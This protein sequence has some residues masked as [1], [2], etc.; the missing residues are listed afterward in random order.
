LVDRFSHQS[1]KTVKKQDVIFEKALTGIEGLDSITHGGLPRGRVTLL[2]GGAGSGKTLLGL[3]SLVN[4]AQSC[5]EPGI[6]VAFEEDAVQIKKN[7]A[8]FGWQLPALLSRK[9]AILDAKLNPALIVAGDFDLS[10]VMA[11]IAAKAKSLGARRV[12]LDSIDAPLSL[13]D[14]P[15]SWRQELYRLHE[16]LLAQNLTAIITAKTTE[17]AHVPGPFGFLQYLA[18]CSISLNHDI[19]DGVSQR[20]LR[21]HKYRGSKFAENEAPLVIG[22]HGIA[23]AG[24]RGLAG[25]SDTAP[26]ERVSSGIARLDTMLGGGFF[27]G[28]CV[29]VTGSP[30]TAKS[31]LGGEFAA[32]ACRRKEKTLIYS[33]DSGPE[34]MIRNLASV[35]IDLRRGV[36]QGLLRIESA[37]AGG[38]S[39]DICLF[40]IMA[41]ARRHAARNLVI[42][43]ITSLGKQGNLKTAHSV[44]E[45]LAD[46][47]KAEGITLFCTS[48]LGGA[49][50]AVEATQLQIST[51]ADTWIHLS[52]LVKGGERNRALTIIKSRGT[53]HSNQVREL[54]LSD[55]GVTLEDVYAAGGEVLMGTLR[56]E[57]EQAMQIEQDRLE[58]ESRSRQK[59]I[60]AEEAELANRIKSLEADLA[61]LRVRREQ[62][63]K[64]E[65]ERRRKQQE[66]L[67]GVVVRRSGD[68][69]PGAGSKK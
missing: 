27:R 59:T 46:W 47:A 24:V 58:S 53:A 15:A 41:L 63:T 64:A 6:F 28:S 62:L 7:V 57:R 35:G 48:L 8:S 42:D 54:V 11:Q 61:A 1:G 67:S 44:V 9:L 66:Q 50:E 40:E 39:A 10:G 60:D 65:R 33:F 16:W 31:T 20:S 37:R 69:K 29:L 26:S 22:E 56:W 45:R 18:D 2:S 49:S 51:I 34:E 43:P 19:V 25:H 23:V 13:L 30:G 14:D 32:A 21:V 36:R 55:Q 4:G 17:Q 12:V 3:Q 68:K 38:S 5:N 52:Y